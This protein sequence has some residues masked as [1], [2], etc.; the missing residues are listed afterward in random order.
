MEIIKW[1]SEILLKKSSDVDEISDVERIV[2]DAVKLMR[3]TGGVGLAAPQIGISKRFF[4]LDESR[5][6]EIDDREPAS[7]VTVMINPVILDGF[8]DT[9][10]QEGCLSIP[11]EVF[12][13]MRALFIVVKFQ[14]LA[15]NQKEETFQGFTSIVIQHE[16]DHLDGIVLAERESIERRR[17][18]RERLSA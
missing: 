14:D 9:V 1:P 7:D 18:I 4:I 13:V 17:L 5:L 3:S 6:A 2:D 10:S 11:G 8:G 16:C 12:N 15:G